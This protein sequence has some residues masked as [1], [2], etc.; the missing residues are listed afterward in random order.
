MGSGGLRTEPSGAR[1][2]SPTTSGN[3]S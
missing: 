3:P 2:E 1:E